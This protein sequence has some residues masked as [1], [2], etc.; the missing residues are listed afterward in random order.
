MSVD[1]RALLED[2][3]YLDSTAEE[4]SWKPISLPSWQ[5]FGPRK[6][7]ASAFYDEHLY[8]FGG[9]NAV[10]G[11]TPGGTATPLRNRC[12]D[13]WR[14]KAMAERPEGEF[15]K[16]TGEGPGGI[17]ECVTDPCV[18]A[19]ALAASDTSSFTTRGSSLAA[20][21]RQAPP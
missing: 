15:L 8:V 7:H 12:G 9:K 4:L 16:A 10:S 14:C 5:R 3:Y 2:L 1:T 19:A 17:T 18:T 20:V 6:H 11:G 13:V 21:V